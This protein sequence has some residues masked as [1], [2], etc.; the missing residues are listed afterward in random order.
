[1][2]NGVNVS[3]SDVETASEG[4]VKNIDNN[5]SPN[6]NSTV[7]LT[8]NSGHIPTSATFSGYQGSNSPIISGNTVTITNVKISAK[9][10]SFCLLYTSRCV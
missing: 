8:I 6:S 10:P 4:V 3:G 1:M 9:Q 2:V 7:V 5:I